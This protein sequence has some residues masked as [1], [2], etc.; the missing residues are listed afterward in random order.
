MRALQQLGHHGVLDTAL[1]QGRYVSSKN[2]RS[3]FLREQARMLTHT[4]IVYKGMARFMEFVGIDHLFPEW[5]AWVEFVQS[6][7][8]L[9]L[10]LDSMV[11]SHPVEVEGKNCTI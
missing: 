8:G 4:T 10:S 3:N 9:A 2:A 1:S 7:Y 11:T 6:V 5:N